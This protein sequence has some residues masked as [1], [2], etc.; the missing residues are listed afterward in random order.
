[1]QSINAEY[2]VLFDVLSK[3]D[4]TDKQSYTHEEDEQFKA[5]LTEITAFNM[6]VQ[7]IGSW[8][9]CFDCF[10][11]K[12][13]LKALGF[14]WCSKKRAWVWHS[15]PYHRYHKKEIPLSD[16]KSKYG[17]QTVRKQSYQYSL[18]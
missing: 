13:Q 5:I 6:T 14:T 10:Q 7:I 12:D 1:M 15:E 2:D 18:N 3:A 16:I 8:I 11:Y 9:W 17:C 4:K